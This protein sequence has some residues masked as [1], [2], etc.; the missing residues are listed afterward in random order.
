MALFTIFTGLWCSYWL[1]HMVGNDLEVRRIW[2][3]IL[4]RFS[5]RPHVFVFE[6]WNS[7]NGDVEPAEAGYTGSTMMMELVELL[8]KTGNWG[9]FLFGLFGLFFTGLF[10]YWLK[11]PMMKQA[12]ENERFKMTIDGY[13]ALL[14]GQA[15]RI[16]YLEQQEKLRTEYEEVLIKRLRECEERHLRTT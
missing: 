13:K 6:Y 14:T 2:F 16:I 10:G 12:V 1:V 9:A 15:N 8:G 4:F 7:G 5:V 11:K 3:T